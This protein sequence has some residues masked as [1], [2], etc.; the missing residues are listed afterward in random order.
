[1]F[2]YQYKF[3]RVNN[4]IYKILIIILFSL[5][6]LILLGCL[7]FEWLYSCSAIFRRPEKQ[8]FCLLF[9]FGVGGGGVLRGVCW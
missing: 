1:M 9:N 7:H 5:R 6:C 3:L 8:V 2:S 4:H